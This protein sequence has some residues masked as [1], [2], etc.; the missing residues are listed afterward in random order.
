MWVFEG[1]QLGT[2][3][4]LAVLDGLV[5]LEEENITEEEDGL[6]M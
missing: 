5:N 6:L 3:G 1:E 4:T 2:E